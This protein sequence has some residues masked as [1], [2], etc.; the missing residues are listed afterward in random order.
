M[1]RRPSALGLQLLSRL[2]A[3]PPA[4]SRL[5]FSLPAA[6]RT[7]HSS[8]C[9]ARV[10]EKVYIVY[11]CG[12]GCGSGC[13][14][15]SVSERVCGCCG[16]SYYYY[17]Y[18]YCYSSSYYDY[19][20][21]LLFWLFA[22]C[23]H[24]HVPTRIHTT[25]PHRHVPLNKPI[26]HHTGIHVHTAPVSKYHVYVCTVAAVAFFPLACPHPRAVGSCGAGRR[27]GV[28]R[29]SRPGSAC[30]YWQNGRGGINVVMSDVIQ[31]SGSSPLPNPCRRIPVRP[32]S[33][34]PKGGRRGPRRSAV[35][36][37]SGGDRLRRGSQ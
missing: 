2:P 21:Q 20:S 19:D 37:Q 16:C 34:E 18:Y 8:I 13:V 36:G 9:R 1:G 30:R 29:A 22:R 14:Y 26:A 28:L 11:E 31:R 5:F 12:C 25:G 4:S 27:A 6:P 3:C 32:F 23:A 7:W 17:Y 24:T 10:H 35:I 33:L 15:Q